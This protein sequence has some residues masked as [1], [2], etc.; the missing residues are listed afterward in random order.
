[1][2]HIAVVKRKT[3][4]INSTQLVIRLN[5]E[6]ALRVVSNQLMGFIVK[7]HNLVP[8]VVLMS[9]SFHLQG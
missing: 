8:K 9:Q 5:A 4:F 6:S 3:S 1:M 7:V 2:L